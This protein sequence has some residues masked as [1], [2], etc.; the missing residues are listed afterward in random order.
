M[1]DRNFRITAAWCALIS[2]VLAFGTILVSAITLNMDAALFADAV[3][4]NAQIV[5]PLLANNPTLAWWPSI[6]DFFGFYLLLLPMALYLHRLFKEEA[7]DWMNLFTVCGLGYILFGAMGAATLAVV[8]S[9]Q[10]ADYATT[11]GAVQQMHTLV[12]EAF[13][14]A[15]QRAV[16][17]ILDPILAGIWWTGVG[18]LLRKYRPVLGWYTVFLGVVN[19][20]GGFSAALGIEAVASICLNLYFLMAPIWAASMGI[21][22]L[23][24]E[25]KSMSLKAVPAD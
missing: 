23:R 5:L 2:M 6:F 4:D 22:L 20:V 8:F 7:P 17:G 21:S 24:N 13:G 11:T 12:F 15:I 1:T 14:D 16:W 18:L 3:N 10:A 19:L 9:A 25:K